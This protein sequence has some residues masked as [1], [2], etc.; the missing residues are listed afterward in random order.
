LPALTVVPKN[1]SKPDVRE[2]KNEDW[3]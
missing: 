1:I 3:V 2:G